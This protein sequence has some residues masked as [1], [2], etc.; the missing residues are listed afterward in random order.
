MTGIAAQFI[1]VRAEVPDFISEQDYWTYYYEAETPY[2]WNNGRL[3]TRPVSDHLTY[4]VYDWVRNL[5]HAFLE[6]HPIAST[7]GLEMGFRMALPGKTVIRKPDLGVVRH[8]NS[9]PLLPLDRSFHGVFDL[10][11]EALSESTPKEARRDTV[12]K[13]TEYRQGGVPEYYILHHDLSRCA[14]YA[15]DPR[16]HYRPIPIQNGVLRSR[17]LPDFCFRIQDLIKR[18]NVEAMLEDPVYQGF[19]LPAWQAD[20]QRAEAERQRAEIERRRAKAER[21]RAETALSEKEAE[22]QR[23]EAERQRA[24]TALS[25]KEAERQ[26]AARLAEQLRALGVDPDIL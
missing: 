13:K 15:R 14:F 8:D 7:T 5:L 11:I 1:P 24:E 10:C 4:V 21:Q 23:A 12:T 3:E 19:V 6:T 26:R 22:R 18:P 9:V 25:E 20:R 16:G 2:E 17:V